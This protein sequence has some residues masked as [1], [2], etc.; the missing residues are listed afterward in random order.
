MIKEAIRYH[1]KGF[2]VI[3]VNAES[4]RP[5][6]KWSRFQKER[7]D[8]DM[9]RKWFKQFPD[10]GIGI[11]TG[12]ISDLTVL[13]MDSAV[14]KEA[15][16][17]YISDDL[18]M[19]ISKTPRGYHAYFNGDSD[20][21]NGVQVLT[22]VDVRSQGGYVIAPPSHCGNGKYA[23]L[24]GYS[25]FD[26]DIPI[27]PENLK[28]LLLD[29]KSSPS[30]CASMRVKNMK[31]I[32]NSAYESYE[33]YDPLVFYE[34][35]MKSYFSEG[36]RDDT[37]FNLG[38]ALFRGNM[39]E[40]EIYKYMFYIGKNCNP[41][42]E[43]DDIKHAFESA[44]QAIRRTDGNISAGF[45]DFVHD[46]GSYFSLKESYD[47]LNI[48]MSDR[49]SK[50]IIY[51]QI[52]KMIKKGQLERHPQRNDLYRKVDKEC[53]VIDFLKA[54]GASAKLWLPFKLHKMVDLMAGNIIVVAGEP[55]SGKTAFL[56]NVI[57]RNM[58][59]SEVH[60]FSSEMG[61]SELR[62]RLLKY[63]RLDLED[64]CFSPY[65][66]SDN[67][68]DVIKPSEGTINIIDF[69]E[70]Y[71]SFYEVGGKIADIHKK[72]NG[73]LCLIA[74]QKNSG[75]DLAVG[76]FRSLEKARLY[77]AMGQGTIKIVKAKNFK[78]NKNPNGQV[79]DFK[80]VNGCDFI[81]VNDWCKGEINYL[82]DE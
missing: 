74:L 10:A 17:E 66:R 41:P 57:A 54:E 18:V 11:V 55:N 79:L 75:R 15:L 72:L 46:S 22:D 78:G 32:K 62:K 34:G 43:E 56:L 76:G 33:S 58:K 27:L 47:H 29:G 14:G 5:L 60:Y 24:N 13:D 52:H 19:P 9:I 3:P 7:A 35:L 21:K 25:I 39:P 8:R 20:L 45:R 71:D 80:L 16:D 65:E 38:C 51:Q 26:V 61:G 69:L 4:K 48:L 59:R 28:A 2:S 31:C 44:K 12:D 40:E 63:D 49:R 81:V 68:A 1:K 67:F 53:D 42:Q 73:A 23:W 37:L 70:I 30:S 77:L 82:D 50:N 36:S 64:W 6:V